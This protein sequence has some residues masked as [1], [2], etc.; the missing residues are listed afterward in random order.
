MI[1]LPVPMTAGPTMRE[2]LTRA[3]SSI[4]TRPMISLVSSTSPSM[5]GS[6]CSR[7]ERLTSSMSPTFPVSF[8]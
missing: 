3:P 8:Q 2:P 7:T 1:T 6:V 4:C 5:R